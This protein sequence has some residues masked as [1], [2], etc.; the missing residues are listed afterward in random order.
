MGNIG[1]GSTMLHSTPPHS[2]PCHATPH[3]HSALHIE[4]DLHFGNVCG[5]RRL[6]EVGIFTQYYVLLLLL[7]FQLLSLR[8]RK[9]NR[10][11]HAWTVM[12][13]HGEGRETDAMQ[14]GKVARQH[15]RKVA[16]QEGSCEPP[17]YATTSG[18]C[19]SVELALPHVKTT[20]TPTLTETETDS[21]GA[22]ESSLG[23]T[24]CVRAFVCVC[25]CVCVYGGCACPVIA[26]MFNCLKLEGQRVKQY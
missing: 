18:I 26:L 16:R 3:R 22:R 8:R 23:Q 19:T 15:C 4:F 24:V 6:S 21:K 10:K 13:Q 20:P 5:L 12:G 1:R 9:A 2:T 25:V 14:A 17:F 7:L 11:L